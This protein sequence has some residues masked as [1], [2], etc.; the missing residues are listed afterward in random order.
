[1]KTFYI[2]GGCVAGVLV[3]IAVAFLI[4]IG[5]PPWVGLP[6]AAGVGIVA[7]YARDLS[8]R[9]PEGADRA[10]LQR[11]KAWRQKS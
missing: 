4:E 3:L 5:T 8:K 1:M 6:L 7:W 11:R 10:R 2:V 9:N